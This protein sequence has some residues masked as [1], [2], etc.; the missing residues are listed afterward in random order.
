LTVSL[1]LKADEV[2]P[3]DYINDF[4][5][6]I[7]SM[8]EFLSLSSDFPFKIQGVV[9]GKSLIEWMRCLEWYNANPRVDV[10]GITYFDVPEDLKDKVYHYGVPD[11]AE[12]ARLH[13]IHLI[14]AGVWWTDEGWKVGTP[15]QK[16]IHLLGC[17]HC[18]ALTYYRNYPL[19][20]S[21][22]TSFPVQLGVEGRPLTLDA[23]KPEFKVQFSSDV[24]RSQKALISQ[25]T[26]RF[27]ELCRG[28]EITRWD[29]TDR[30][31]GL[32]AV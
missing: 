30:M 21:I 16:P 17:R 24:V 15:L 13:L 22:D 1:D 5:R 2:V 3:T 11:I 28:R 19:I 31:A 32:N 14:H 26:L 9:Q 25:N 12:A 4:T 23:V 7:R 20:R 10:I 29:L 27:L 18:R 8:E 6:T